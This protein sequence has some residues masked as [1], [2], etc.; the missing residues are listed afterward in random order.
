MMFEEVFTDEGSLTSELRSLY[1]DRGRL[2]IELFLEIQDRLPGLYST[3]DAA[4]IYYID[5]LSDEDLLSD[6]SFKVA[7][8]ML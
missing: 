2:D 5:Q 7:E 4:I 1:N 3:C 6:T 8:H